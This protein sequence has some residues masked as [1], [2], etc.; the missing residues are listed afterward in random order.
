MLLRKKN[1]RVFKGIILVIAVILLIGV[2]SLRDVYIN[3]EE[4]RDKLIR[5]HVIANSDSPQDQALKLEV[6]DKVINTMNE[7]FAKST[8]LDQ[9]RE[10]IKD[11]LQE[12]QSIAQ[13]EVNV[14][15]SN[16][17]V[18]VDFGQ[19]SF[20]T[21]SYGNFTL[22]AGEYQAVEIV[23]G[24]GKGANWWC[25]MFPPLCFIDIENGLTDRDTKEKLRDVLTEEEYKMIT[26]VQE[27]EEVPLKLKFKIVEIFEKSKMTFAKMFVSK[28]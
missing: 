23:I 26:Q 14:Q 21:K 22:P 25:V 15:G 13:N 28:K 20:P 27:E 10:I 17:D 12:I 8:S 24:E 5:F 11:N 1:K 18:N 2:V 7:K 9:S 19:H 16:Y 3:R 6:R 4:Y